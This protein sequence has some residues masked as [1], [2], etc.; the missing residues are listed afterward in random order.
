MG[1]HVLS[2]G[3]SS[4][5]VGK[6]IWSTRCFFPLLLGWKPLARPGCVGRRVLKG[7][8]GHRLIGSLVVVRCLGLRV[9]GRLAKA[10][11]LCI[12]DLSLVD[13]ETFE[14]PMFFRP[15][16]TAAEDE[17]SRRHQQHAA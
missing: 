12:R 15:C 11:I 3:R 1:W 9:I 8:A 10:V 7:D 14:R 17:R 2:P 6:T 16:C 13:V 4:P 5:G